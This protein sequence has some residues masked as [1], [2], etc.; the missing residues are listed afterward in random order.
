[1]FIGN[2][3]TS[4][5]RYAVKHRQGISHPAIRLLSDQPQSCFFGVDAFALRHILQMLGDIG[6]GDPL[7]VIDLTA[8]E[9]RGQDLVLLRRGEDEDRIGWGLFER[10]EEGVEGRRGE[11]VHLVDDVDLVAPQ[12]GR[13]E[14]L[15]GELAN[16]LDGVIR[17][18]VQLEDIEGALLVE[19]SATLTRIARLTFG[20]EV[21]AVDGLGQH[22]GRRRLPDPS[23]A[24]EEVGVGELAREDRRT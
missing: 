21:H 20:G 9:D 15:L 4:E 13:H 1:M 5:A 16:I 14:H 6:D 18:S 22:T 2:M 7:E 17:S 23:R 10:L 8:G 3:S 11:H 24:T 19:G 12:S